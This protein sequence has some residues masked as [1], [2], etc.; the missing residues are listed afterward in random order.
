LQLPDSYLFLNYYVFKGIA[1]V[2]C[3]PFLG[4]IN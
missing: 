4:A 1:E 3:R 2:R